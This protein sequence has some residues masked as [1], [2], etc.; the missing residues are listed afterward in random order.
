M[1]KYSAFRNRHFAIGRRGFT[2]IEIIVLI[3]LAGIIIPVI[4][5][6]FAT[7]I[8]GS[9]KPEMVTTAMYFAHQRM[10]E[11]MKYNYN[12]AA[13]N[14]T[15]GFV[16]FTTGGEPNYSGQNEILYVNNDLST[17]AVSPGV[18]YKR[19]IVR[20][21]DPETITYEVYGVVTNFP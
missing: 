19:I 13:L 18:G 20:V 8:R 3:V 17:P 12:N 11:L 15:A 6:P 4:I 14:V 1:K 16:A 9:K 2:L 21:T 5:I 10:E 7:G